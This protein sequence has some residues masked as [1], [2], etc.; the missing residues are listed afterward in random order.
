ML[1]HDFAR[2]LTEAEKT[3]RL[4]P[5]DALSYFH[6]ANAHHA[7]GHLELAVA[8][9]TTAI[10]LHEREVSRNTAASPVIGCPAPSAGRSDLRA[11]QLCGREFVLR[12]DRV[13]LCSSCAGLVPAR[14]LLSAN[15][16]GAPV[17]LRHAEDPH[18]CFCGH[19]RDLHGPDAPSKPEK[20]GQ[21]IE[22]ICR[23]RDGA[24]ACMCRSFSPRTFYTDDVHGGEWT[25][26]DIL[27]NEG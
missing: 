26:P 7:L 17:K 12:E 19:S 5:H 18:V 2:A 25:V 20:P 11:C 24:A 27:A 10:E 9:Y 13:R 16:S 3:I 22:P 6:R 4:Q 23:G 1:Q 15:R 8:D 14:P 21:I